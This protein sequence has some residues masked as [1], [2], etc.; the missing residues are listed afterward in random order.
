MFQHLLLLLYQFLLLL[1]NL[2]LKHFLL[3][4]YFL[5]WSWTFAEE[6]FYFWDGVAFVGGRRSLCSFGT[7]WL[8]HLL[9]INFIKCVKLLYLN[10]ISFFVFVRNERRFIIRPLVLI[11]ITVEL[12]LHTI[13]RIILRI[14]IRIV[15]PLIHIVSHPSFIPF[16]FVIQ[17]WLIL[18]IDWLLF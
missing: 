6:H 17:V 14:L 3:V 12:F 5:I 4:Q 16:S 15:I 18:C 7:I 8:I 13:Y 11:E 9:I 1:V 2:L 10:L